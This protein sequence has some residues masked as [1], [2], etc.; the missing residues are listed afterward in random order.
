LRVV[1][2]GTPRID[3]FLALDRVG[4]DWKVVGLVLAL[5]AVGAQ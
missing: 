5:E 3:Q 2:V 4:L 1:A